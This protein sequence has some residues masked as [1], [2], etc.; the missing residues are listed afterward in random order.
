MKRIEDIYRHRDITKM[1]GLLHAYMQEYRA[2]D[3]YDPLLDSF[4]LI[5]IQKNDIDLE[6]IQLSKNYDVYPDSPSK[7]TRHNSIMR[8][9]SPVSSN[10]DSNR[11]KSVS[12]NDCDTEIIYEEQTIETPSDLLHP[13]FNSKK[14][15]PPQSVR[16][17]RADIPNTS[18]KEQQKRNIMRV[19][20]NMK[21]KEEKTNQRTCWYKESCECSVF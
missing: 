18:H 7:L 19:E 17:K 5:M 11:K 21:Q 4:K 9:F 20:E 12:F 2:C 1:R 10:Y 15:S 8:Q 14:R 16:D 6:I 13:Y 3:Y